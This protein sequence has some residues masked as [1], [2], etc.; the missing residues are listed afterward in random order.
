V[1]VPIAEAVQG[2]LAEKIAPGEAADRLMWR[3]LRPENE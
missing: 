1:K 2:V 3:Q